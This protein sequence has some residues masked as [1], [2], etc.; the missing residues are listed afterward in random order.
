MVV[1]TLRQHPLH[2]VTF[3]LH[4]GNIRM[5]SVVVTYICVTFTLHSSAQGAVG[6][7]SVADYS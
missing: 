4:L 7:V 1:P 6:C 3:N 5:H 2:S